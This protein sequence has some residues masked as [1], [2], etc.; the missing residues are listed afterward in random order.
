MKTYSVIALVL[1]GLLANSASADLVIT[2]VMS[3]SDHPGGAANGD[4]FEITN[5]CTTAIDL[6]NYYWDDGGPMANDGALF[7]SLSINPGES[8]VIVDES[9]ANLSGFVSA[10]GGGFTAVS[11]DDF[12][13]MNDF[14]GL[15]SGGDM[16]EIWDADP[17]AGPANLVA[18]V[19][20]GDSDGGGKSFQ[21]DTSGNF[22]GFSVDGVNGAFTAIGDGAGG[23]GID[24]ASP[25]SAVPEPGSIAVL[26][27]IGA[28]SLL[29]RRK[30]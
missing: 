10:W 25:G 8:I 24:V 7:P 29:R 21:W 15:G 2:E 20:F 16:I 1:F 5:A 26:F 6:T 17:N 28:A 19:M 27:G 18:S 3:N 22:L 11:K 13:G 30:K 9:A 14:S 12:G 23:M 4:W